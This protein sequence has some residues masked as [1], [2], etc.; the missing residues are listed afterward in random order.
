[1]NSW[2]QV[3]YDDITEGENQNK[4]DKIKVEWK[5]NSKYE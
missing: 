4:T 2:V 1:M 3:K 5:T